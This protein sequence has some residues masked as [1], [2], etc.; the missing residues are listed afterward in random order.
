MGFE[1]FLMSFLSCPENKSGVQITI[2]CLELT[3]S[4]PDIPCGVINTFWSVIKKDF[5]IIKAKSYG[6]N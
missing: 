1:H 5:L 4:S 2:L 6:G 3:Y